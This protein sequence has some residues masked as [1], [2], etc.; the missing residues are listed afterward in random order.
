MVTPNPSITMM[1]SHNER[2]I[3]SYEKA[4]DLVET[5]FLASKFSG[6]LGKCLSR[7]RSLLCE[8]DQYS[9]GFFQTQTNAEIELQNNRKIHRN[10]VC[11]TRG[12]AS[13]QDLGSRSSKQTK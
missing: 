2:S 4:Q 7:K 10:E 5:K 13:K 12:K 3:G 11:E 9:T 6:Q 1:S 8:H